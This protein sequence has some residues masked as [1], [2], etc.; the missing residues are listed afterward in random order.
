MTKQESK[1]NGKLVSL[2]FRLQFVLL[3]ALGIV[4]VE[5]YRLQP[6]FWNTYWQPILIVAIGLGILIL[7]SL[8]ESLWRN[9]RWL[10]ASAILILIVLLE[11]SWFKATLNVESLEKHK[12]SKYSIPQSN[13]TIYV[14]Y[15]TQVL[16]DSQNSPTLAIWLANPIP[17]SN[18]TITVAA[19]NLVFASQAYEGSPL[20]WVNTLTVTLPADGGERTVLFKPLSNPKITKESKIVIT[21]NN[22][23]IQ[24]EYPPII[25]LEGE[26]NA[27]RRLWLFALIDTG[28]ISLVVGIAFAWFETQRKSDEEKRKIE[29]AIKQAKADREKAI[30]QAEEYSVINNFIEDFSGVL[31]KPLTLTADW[32]EWDER[33][34]EQFRK[35]YSS[36]FEEK[37][38]AGLSDKTTAEMRDGVDLCLQLCIRIFEDEKEKPIPLLKQLQSALVQ[39]ENAPLSLLSTLKEYP[40]SI[41]VAKQIVSAFPGDLKNKTIAEYIGKFPDQIRHLRNE[42]GFPDTESFPMQKQFAFYAKSHTYEDRLTAWLKARELD[43]SPFADAESPFY[44]VPDKLLL[45]DSVAPGFTLPPSNLQNT[46]FEFT[47]SWDAGAALFQYCKSLPIKIKDEMFFVAI[48]PSLIENH[49]MDQPRKLYL[50]AL[51]EQWIWS[52]V[53]TQTFF[54]SLKDPQRDLA[55]RLLRWHDHSPSITVNKIAR[56]SG[57]SEEAKNQTIFSSKIKEWLTA[58]NSDDLQAEEVNALIELRPLPKQRTLFIISTIDLNPQA[59]SQISTSLH[60]KLG[61]ESDWLSIHDCQQTHFQ[62]GNKSPLLVPQ[63]S[64][65][66]QCNNRIRICSQNKVNAFNFLF[67]FH[68][69]EPAEHILARKA[70]GSPGKMIR[71]GQKLLLQHVENHSPDEDLFIEDLIAIK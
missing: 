36:N 38:W 44:S 67:A 45:I 7:L 26:R 57:F 9:Y 20:Q 40:A 51:A 4:V 16:Y 34:Q 8:W 53:E 10:L 60:E 18:Q 25:I 13:A 69:E 11:I 59:D 28:S 31:K 50:H 6:S 63:N 46:I 71:L 70:A 32:K 12:L 23:E 19:N 47:N 48:A 5:I 37:L 54:Y 33:L 65:V 56:Y 58:A 2:D 29:D 41:V 22:E 27:Q 21:S 55:G 3:G 49:G 61:E 68:N 1:R 14:E 39:D 15:P 66:T 24:I 64:L 52:L 35:I 42:L 30:K 17:S 43:Y 62:I